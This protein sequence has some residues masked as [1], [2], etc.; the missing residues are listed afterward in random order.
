[1]LHEYESIGELLYGNA[2]DVWTSCGKCKKSPVDLYNTSD[3]DTGKLYVPNA[4]KTLI[5][6]YEKG[7]IALARL[8]SK[9]VKP[10]SDKVKVREHIQ[11]QIKTRGRLDYHYCGMYGFMVAKDEQQVVNNWQKNH[12]RK[13]TQNKTS[14]PFVART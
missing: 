5:S 2:K 3:P 10:C 12:T 7:Q 6:P 11:G 8:I 4:L 13:S 14:S 9:S 1:M